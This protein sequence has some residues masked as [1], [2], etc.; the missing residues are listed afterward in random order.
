MSSSRAIDLSIIIS[1]FGLLG[2]RLFAVF[3]SEGGMFHGRYPEMASLWHGG[4]VPAGLLA[5]VFAAILVFCI[6]HRKRFLIIADE[7]VIPLCLLLLMV[8]IGNHLNGE[9]YG[10][11][12]GVWWGVKF[13]YS[14]GFRHPVALYE[15]VKNCIIFFVLLSLA[16]RSDPGGGKT[17]AHFI[18][19]SGLGSFII[20]RF[21]IGSSLPFHMGSGQ[22]VS[23]LLVTVGFLLII[24]AARKKKKYA[25]LSTL[26]FVP[27]SFRNR[28]SLATGTIVLKIVLF[29]VI[30]IFCL[31]IPSGMSR[32]SIKDPLPVNSIK[33]RV[34][35]PPDKEVEECRLQVVENA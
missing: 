22:I 7:I 10:T 16:G 11:I 15:A 9:S 27:I 18:L 20:G 35:Y 21:S 1:I 14:D 4:M 19:W 13:P 30:L 23:L 2:G 34:L 17:T 28:A 5:G 25:D 8:W 33:K 3:V 29:V 32:Q 24:R 12:T 6:I 26:Q 31:T